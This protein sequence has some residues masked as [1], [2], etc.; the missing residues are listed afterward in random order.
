M[1]RKKHR[2][3][4][5][6]N[7]TFI[8]K[9]QAPILTTGR[10]DLVLVY[11]EHMSVRGEIPVP[12]QIWKILKHE[13]GKAYFKARMQGTLIELIEQVEDPGW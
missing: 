12:K 1:K 2:R 7:R 10:D 5:D 6:P 8:V 13:C 11:D 3:S 4:S 9:V